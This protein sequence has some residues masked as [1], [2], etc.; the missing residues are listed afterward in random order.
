MPY[1]SSLC[2]ACREACP[3]KINIPRMLLYLRNQLAEGASYPEHK[4][5]SLLE[6]LAFKGWRISLSSTFAL[7]AANRFARLMQKPF[8]HDG[9]IRR[10]PGPLAAWT[11]YRTFP[12]IAKK[13]FR[14]RWRNNSTG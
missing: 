9:T 12:A 5:S 10:L 3:V 11:K 2:G 4:S 8:V 6:R 7:G 13:P 1:A 14:K